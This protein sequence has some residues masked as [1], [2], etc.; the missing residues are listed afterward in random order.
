M[1][2]LFLDKVYNIKHPK[3]NSFFVC[4]NFILYIKKVIDFISL[5]Y[6]YNKILNNKYEKQNSKA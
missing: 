5:T 4:S 6:N 1:N 2:Q 3:F